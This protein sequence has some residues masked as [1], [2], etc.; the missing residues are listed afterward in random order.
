M[1]AFLAGDLRPCLHQVRRCDWPLAH[2]ILGQGMCSVPISGW[3]GSPEG[4]W[5]VSIR[6]VW[7]IVPPRSSILC[8]HFIF[9]DRL[10]PTYTFHF[11][12][13]VK[14]KTEDKPRIPTEQ[15]VPC[16]SHPF[17]ARLVSNS[18]VTDLSHFQDVRLIEFDITESN[19]KWVTI[20]T[21]MLIQQQF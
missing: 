17:P 21:F 12:D 10:P 15:P 9:Y 19:I 20:S 11:L 7:R 3:R 16:Q 4:R 13:N 8:W 14:E 2:I 18:R 6:M 5:S 1:D